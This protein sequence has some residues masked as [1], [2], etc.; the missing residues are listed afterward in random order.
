MGTP[1]ISVAP[2][3]AILVDGTNALGFSLL[4]NLS[5]DRKTENVLVSPLSV[6]TA[7][8]MAESGAAG[9]TQSEMARLLGTDKMSDEARGQAQSALADSLRNPPGIKLSVANSLWIDQSFNLKPDFQARSQKTF[10][11]TLETLDFEVPASVTRINDWVKLQTGGKIDEIIE[12][13][14]VDDRAVLVN[15]VYFRGDWF[16]EFNKELTANE[17]FSTPARAVQ[18]PLMRSASEF[19]Y[20]DNE[21]FQM[22]ALPYKGQQMAFYIVL[23]R[24]KTGLNALIQTLDAPALKANI[25]T[26]SVREGTVY[27]PR[28]EVKDSI[29]LSAPLQSL[30]MKTAFNVERA[31]FSRMA[32]EKVFIGK[33]LHKTTLEVNEV[34]TV[35]AAT[36]AVTAVAGAAE[37]PEALKPFVLRADRP[38]LL[39][40]RDDKTGAILFLGIINQPKS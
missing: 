29:E 11:A 18:V 35:A 38:F 13:L 7:L 22:V 1:V 32:S 21:K 30:G 31:D 10:G 12:K 9:A 5:A 8:S 3:T 40:L 14:N 28:F 23:P 36:S 39:A 24:A 17:T 26:M 16:D 19:R 25:A 33:V 6:S 20:T 37:D 27:L 34:G 4:K 15:A 2:E